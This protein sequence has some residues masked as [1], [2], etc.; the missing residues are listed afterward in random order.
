M[1]SEHYYRSKPS[2]RQLQVGS[3]IQRAIMEELLMD[4][5][6]YSRFG[7][8]SVSG[9]RMNSGL[10]SATIMFTI[11]RDM[12]SKAKDILKSL[13]QMSGYFRRVIASKIDLRY[14]PEIAFEYDKAGSDVEIL[15]DNLRKI[16]EAEE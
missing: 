13:K 2:Q 12:T 16:H 7:M 8:I 10:K 11:S 15:H 3:A 4:E 14:V 1:T 9:V 5:I 6:L